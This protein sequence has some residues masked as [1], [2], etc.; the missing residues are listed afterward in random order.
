MGLG[1]T[2]PKRQMMINMMY[3]VL[4]AL[5]ALNVSKQVLKAFELVN[6][7]LEVTNGAFT[8][9]NDNTYAAFEKQMGINAAK[10]KPYY[11]KAQIVKTE[12]A[13]LI[14]QIED[15]KQALLSEN[16]KLK[17]ADDIYEHP[18]TKEDI[19]SASDIEI[20]T[21][22]FTGPKEKG[23]EHG[24]LLQGYLKSYRSKMESLIA[25]KDRAGSKLININDADPNVKAEAD[26]TG[27]KW[28]HYYF[29][30]VPLVADVTV[31][32][33][34]QND[35]KNTESNMISYL[36]GTIGQDDFKFDQLDAIISSDKPIVLQ[37][38]QYEAKIFLGAHDSHQNPEIEMNG[39]QLKVENGVAE[40]KVATTG[41]GERKLD[42]KIIVKA[43]D[44]TKKEYPF[45]TAYQVF[46]G[47]AVISADKMNV[48]YVGLENPISVSC[49]GYPP[50]KIIATTTGLSSWTG[51]AGK[52]IA[53]PAD[54]IT[55][56]EAVITV[57]VKT[58]DNS[59]K[60]MGT[61]TFRIK[62]MPKPKVLLGTLDG[63]A[64]SKVQL[65]VQK[66]VQANL[67]NFVYEGIKYTVVKYSWTFAPK[68]AGRQVQGPET[69]NG[70]LV[71]AALTNL[72]TGARTGD[73]VLISD[74]VASGPTGQVK[75]S[76]GPTF[77]IQ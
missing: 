7:G 45:K 4:T 30:E 46:V 12:S 6:S 27:N 11:D 51:S 48:L 13:S 9:K 67:E 56:K 31:L 41:E 29:A 62:R 34:M 72:V 55:V 69:V 22:F 61:K 24:A 42:G 33:K 8:K 47:S 58:G 35:V 18:D 68:G 44:G 60:Q 5:L 75:I 23:G 57:S 76:S 39:Q 1:K 52:F 32:T 20:G 36:F 38:Q 15:M 49:P 77:I 54:A 66:V 64:I 2:N 28:A 73:L 3:L 10:V 25:E 43:P 21:N 71:P 17:T 59:V 26:V 16:G 70:Q 19:K 53:K 63:G 40:Y 65:S 50:D 74:I 14:K 37:G